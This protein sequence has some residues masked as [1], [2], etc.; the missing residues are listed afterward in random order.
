MKATGIVRRVDD[1]GRL[2]IPKELRRTLHIKEAD[3]IEFYVEGDTIVLKKYDV[4]GDLA[5]VLDSTESYIKQNDLLPVGV[6]TALLGKVKEM[7]AIV[8][9]EAAGK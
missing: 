6:L 7:R 5:Q 2:V 8:D 1:L 4:M 9:K 3:P